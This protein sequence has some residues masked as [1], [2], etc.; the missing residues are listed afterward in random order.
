MSQ[1]RSDAI[2]CFDGNAKPSDPFWRFVD[3]AAGQDPELE[4]YGPISEFIWVEDAN[5]PMGE[6]MVNLRE[7]FKSQLYDFGKGGPVT[8]RI[9]SP[10]GDVF[11]ASMLRSILADYPGQVTCRIDGV[12]ASAATV[13]AMAGDKITMMDTSYMMIHDPAVVVFLASLDINLLSELLDKLKTIK[14]GIVNAYETRSGLSRDRLA[15]MMSAETWMSARD[16]LGLGF[17]DEIISAG[18]AAPKA[19]AQA[20]SNYFNVPRDL[21]VNCEPP[22]VVEPKVDEH[23]AQRLRDYLDVFA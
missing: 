19:P 14:D 2:R 1:Q 7:Q 11:A 23:A 5:S 4:L 20:Y 15:K 9:N 18:K 13:V 8:V 21:V 12:C 17:A 22:V 6:R 3:A 10:G 16:A